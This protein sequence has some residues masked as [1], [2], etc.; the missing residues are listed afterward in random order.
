MCKCT[1][2]FCTILRKRKNLTKK[3]ALLHYQM[4]VNGKLRNS[5]KIEKLKNWG[6]KLKFDGNSAK[7]G[8]LS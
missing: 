5:M 2:F 7:I 1:I 8:H 6:F 4:K 3:T